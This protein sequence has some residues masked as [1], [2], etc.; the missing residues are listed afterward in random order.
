MSSATDE[1]NLM[2]SVREF[3][4]EAQYDMVVYQNLFIFND[5]YTIIV[6]STIQ[7]IGIAV[8]SIFIVSIVLLSN[9]VAIL[10]VTLSVISIFIG[11]IGYLALWGT[12][13]NY[14][15]AMYLSMCVGFSVDFSAHICYHFVNCPEE[16]TNT[17]TGQCLG[18]LG[19]PILQG[20]LS[21]ILAVVVLA[22]S[23]EYLFFTFF[24]V[25]FLVMTFGFFHGVVFIPVMLSTITDLRRKVNCCKKK[26]QAGDKENF[27]EE[28][29]PEVKEVWAS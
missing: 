9:I 18:Y 10:W 29:P 13:L 3:V 20:T 15:T 2:L 16:N 1:K 28:S 22:S 19:H 25:V 24:K 6:T 14:I 27:S 8:A 26:K 7:T 23:Q 17:K 4:E 12:T 21:T 11:V 5:Q